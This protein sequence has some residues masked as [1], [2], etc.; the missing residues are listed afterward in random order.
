MPALDQNPLRRVNSK[1]QIF[2]ML[3]AK[4]K[5][6]DLDFPQT[7]VQVPDERHACAGPKSA[8]SS[9]LQAA[10]FSHAAGEKIG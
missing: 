7:F 3:L 8:A 9:E 5:R 1:P 2:H 6:A 4:S 10:D